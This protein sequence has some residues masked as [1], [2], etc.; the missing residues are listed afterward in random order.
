MGKSHSSDSDENIVPISLQKNT[1]SNQD[2]IDQ[3]WEKQQPQYNEILALGSLDEYVK[4]HNI[5]LS[6]SIDNHEL[7]H[8]NAC[9]CMDDRTEGFGLNLAGSGILLAD[10]IGIEALADI[11]KKINAKHPGKI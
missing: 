9:L 7:S 1:M 2:F 6:K 11:I 3:S 5:D 8:G 4:K 10:A